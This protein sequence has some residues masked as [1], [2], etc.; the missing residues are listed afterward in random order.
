MTQHGRL[1]RLAPEPFRNFRRHSSVP[2]AG[3]RN[4]TPSENDEE[5]E[6]A[7]RARWF[8]RQIPA[9]PKKSFYLRMAGMWV[10][11]LA[12]VMSCLVAEVALLGR[13]EQRHDQ[14]IE[15]AKLRGELAAGTAP[16]GPRDYRGAPLPPG[17]PVAIITIPAI[18]VKQVVGEGTTAAILESGPGHKRDTVLPGQIGTSIVMGRSAAYGGPFRYLDQLQPG[19]RVDVTTGQGVSSFRVRDVRRA[20]DLV[21][22]PPGPGQG[23][24]TLVSA[25]GPAFAPTDQIRVDADLTTDVQP[26]PLGAVPHITD[27]EAAMALDLGASRIVDVFLAGLI[28]AARITFRVAPRWGRAK[29]WLVAA[30][31]LLVLGLALA[32]RIALLLPNLT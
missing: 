12:I 29:T 17:D 23:R 20:G 1:A 11:V 9:R 31:V 4:Q 8:R 24:L 13:F 18:G 7:P 21:P 10:S 2:Y 30:P 16:I 5:S 22:A 25:T 3:N 15:Y 14:Q 28:L 6:D 19:D 26:T 32:D 27:A